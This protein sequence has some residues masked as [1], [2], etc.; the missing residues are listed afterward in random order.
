MNSTV[1][2]D[3]VGAA[4]SDTAVLAYLRLL[5]RRWRWIVWGVLATLAATTVFLL[6]RPPVYRSEATVFIRTPGDVSRVVDGGDSYAK[7]R[8]RTY[9]ALAT[10][11]DLAAVVIGDL[12]VKA[13]PV[14]FADRI[15]ASNRTGTVLI[16]IAVTGPTAAETTRTAQVFL[17][18]YAALVHTLETVPGSAVPRAELV[19]VTGPGR[20]EREVAWGAPLYVVIAGAVLTGFVLGAGAAVA[21]RLFEPD[22][23]HEANS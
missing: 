14:R 20:P 5:R 18:D 8:G 7:A 3:A 6:V 17:T 11:P 13:D 1:S 4:Y 23:E 21:R 9:A 10:S 19:V 22:T 2:H 12:K 16:D 15:S